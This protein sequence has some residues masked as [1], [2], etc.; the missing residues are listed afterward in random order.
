MKFKSVSL[1]LLFFHKDNMVSVKKKYKPVQGGFLVLRPSMD[2]YKEFKQLA[3]EGDF[4]E[5]GGWGGLVGPFYGAMTFQGI[6]P[7]YYDVLHPGEAIELNRCVVNQMCDNPRDEKTV[8]DVVHGNCRTGEED[9][10]DCRSRPIEDVLTTHYTLC[11]KPWLCIPHDQDALQHRLC[12]KLHHEWF[13]IRSELEISWGRSGM[14]DGTWQSDHFY[15]YC[16][17]M[18]NKG[19]VPIA[20]P[21]GIA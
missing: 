10:E 14:G 21:Y 20:T 7:Y 3:L 2:V 8:N 9:C 12:R 13:K 15:G 6:M 18:G 16:T 17:A 4:R 11:Q 19:Y 1:P 5:H